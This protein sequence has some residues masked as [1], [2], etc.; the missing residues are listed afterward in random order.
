MGRATHLPSPS[1]EPKLLWRPSAERAERATI[2]RFARAV[3][4]EG[5]YDEL[6]RWSV[7]DLEG[8]WARDLGV[9]RR[10]GLRAV[11]ARA[12]TARDA[13]RASGS[14]GRGCP[15]PSTS[16][17]A[18]TTTRW[19]SATPASCASCRSGRGASCASRP[20]AS[21]PGC[22]AGRRPGRPRRRLH[23]QHPRDDRGLPGHR[24]DRRACG[25]AR[26]P[27]SA[28]AR[29]STAS[30]RSS[31]RCCSPS[32]ATAT[33]GATTTAAR[34][35]PAS[36]RRSARRSCASATSTAAAG[37][38]SSSADDEPLTFEQVP[39]RPP[40]VG[41]LQLGHDR[42]AQADRPQPGRDPARAPQEHA[43]APRRAGGRPRLLVHDDRLDDVELPGRRAAHAGVDR[44]LRRQPGLAGPRRAVGPRR[45][46]PA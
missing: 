33:A 40:A 42:A 32:T 12:R 1:M 43:P 29:W 19:P 39:V 10:A 4:R 20:R 34:S 8:F 17:A 28:R 37:R 2:A 26:R 25:R 24:L 15:T 16:S 27:S 14:R 36:P 9:L 44:P 31:P 3:G 30:R 5:D 45:G 11:R 46:A 6:W 18:A 38:R 22:G 21:P 23:A 35:S 13:G 7:D 41:A